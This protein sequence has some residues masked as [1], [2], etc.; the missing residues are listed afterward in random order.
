MA[1]VALP[2]APAAERKA[3]KESLGTMCDGDGQSA[4]TEVG[5]S[6]LGAA[7]DADYAAV[8]AAYGG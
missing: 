2:S 6:S 5:I 7:S 4:C 8:V 3:F 1:V